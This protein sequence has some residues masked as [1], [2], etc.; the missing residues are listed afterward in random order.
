MREALVFQASASFDAQ[1]GMRR[2]VSF[3]VISGM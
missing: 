2:A 1:R 3:A